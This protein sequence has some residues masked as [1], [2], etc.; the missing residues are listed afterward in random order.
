M[1]HDD[2]SCWYCLFYELRKGRGWYCKRL[3]IYPEASALHI[4]CEHFV[5]DMSLRKLDRIL[6]L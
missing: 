6:G 1:R 3:S 2:F 4:P 5:I